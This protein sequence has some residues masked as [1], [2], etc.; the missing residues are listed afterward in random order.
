MVRE[1][2]PT[3]YWADYVANSYVV[4]NIPNDFYEAVKRFE[5]SAE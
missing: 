1:E 5:I 4:N 2:P 3:E